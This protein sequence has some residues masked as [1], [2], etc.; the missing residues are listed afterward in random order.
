MEYKVFAVSDNDK[1]AEFASIILQK[2][3]EWL[4]VKKNIQKYVNYLNE[5]QCWA[6]FDNDECIGIFFGRILGNKLGDVYLY[7]I[8][9]KYNRKGI[10][11]LLY[12][13]VEEY[14][15]KNGC[16]SIMVNTIDG[17]GPDGNYQKTRNF[18]EKM[19]FAEMLT[20]LVIDDSDTEYLVMMK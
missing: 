15:A 13:K 3:V 10:G 20:T 17:I 8:D 5:Y 2:L 6:A 1:K 14:F 19:G 4:G 11:T 12:K 18:Y 16:E 7:G 9:P